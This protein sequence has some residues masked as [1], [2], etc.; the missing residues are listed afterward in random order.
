M[1]ILGNPW[2]NLV[3]FRSKLNQIPKRLRLRLHCKDSGDCAILCASWSKYWG[4]NCKN[5]PFF[6]Y[7]YHAGKVHRTN[8]W[9]TWG[10][11]DEGDATKAGGGHS[12]SFVNFVICGAQKFTAG[13]VFVLTWSETNDMNFRKIRK[14]PFTRI[15]ICFWIRAN[16][17]GVGISPPLLNLHL[18]FISPPV[19]F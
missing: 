2:S 9:C 11:E 15:R 17:G 6:Q 19:F 3:H 16:R 13:G 7:E 14:L 18:T 4:K 5:K 8:A 10:R 1:R 12:N